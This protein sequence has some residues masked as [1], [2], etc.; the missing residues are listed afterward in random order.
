MTTNVTYLLGAGASAEA[1][2]LV[3]NWKER[4][5]NYVDFL[6]IIH[7][8]ENIWSDIKNLDSLISNYN[9]LLIEAKRHITLD[10]Y[11][12]KLFLKNEF[13]KLN[14][15]KSLISGFFIFEQTSL[16][17]EAVDYLDE[18]LWG[19]GFNELSEK[20]KSVKSNIVDPRYDAF[21]ATFL[22]N[23][24]DKLVLPDNIN[25]ISWNYD[26]QLELAY[27]DY[28]DGSIAEAQQ[29][30]RVY[31]HENLVYDHNKTTWV[32]DKTG[33]K[34]VKLNGNANAVSYVDERGRDS[35]QM[36]TESAYQKFFKSLYELFI[37]GFDEKGNLK[38]RYKWEIN[39]AWESEKNHI[40]EKAVMEA[41]EIIRKTDTLV[42]IG[43]SFPA[44]NR[45]I[46]KT[47]FG[48]HQ[49]Q[50]IYI[51]TKKESFQG[52]KEKLESLSLISDEGIHHRTCENESF[53][54]PFE[55]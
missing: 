48:N 30:L 47:V 15:L 52:I 32:R 12:K 35:V 21:M 26:H 50:K 8:N 19:Q 37:N 40:S 28:S 45:V 43:Y 7:H 27:T 17:L 9:W 22:M 1:L 4:L 53:F 34:I 23:R 49:Y 14:L 39:F 11:A 41:K 16:S 20:L 51:Q 25:I 6:N 46:D 10:T 55:L 31:P 38:S 44:F 54:I 24:E 2:P 29:T 42:I 3:R 5:N 36:L 18:G 13:K 33:Y